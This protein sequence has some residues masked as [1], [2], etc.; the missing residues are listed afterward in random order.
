MSDQESKPTRRKAEPAP[1][2]P[3]TVTASFGEEGEDPHEVGFV[4]VKPKD[5][6]DTVEHVAKRA[7]Q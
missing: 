2:E 4:G 7:Q 5:E 1:A 3:E 6:P